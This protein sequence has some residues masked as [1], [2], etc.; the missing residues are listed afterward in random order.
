KLWGVNRVIDHM[1]GIVHQVYRCK[2]FTVDLGIDLNN[3]TTNHF[4]HN[5]YNPFHEI[6][7]HSLNFAN[8]PNISISHE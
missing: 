4:M 1:T 2:D 7:R 3:V 5:A 6:I 8:D